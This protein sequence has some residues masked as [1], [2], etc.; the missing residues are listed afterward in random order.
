M[1][2]QDPVDLLVPRDCWGCQ[3]FRAKKESPVGMESRDL[4]E[5]VVLLAREV[6]LACLVSQDPRDTEASLDW[7]EPRETMA[8]LVT[9][10]RMDLPVLLVLLD[11]SVPSVREEREGGTDHQGLQESEESMEPWDLLEKL[12]PLERLEEQECLEFLEVRETADLRDPREVLACKDP[13]DRLANLARQATL[14]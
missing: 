10:V 6:W 8:G 13:W 7:T 14:D 5:L 9:R 4:P 12:D 2:I 1:E 11:P 3:D